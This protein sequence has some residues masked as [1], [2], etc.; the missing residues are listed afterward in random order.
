LALFQI[1]QRSHLTAMRSS[2]DFGISSHTCLMTKLSRDGFRNRCQIDPVRIMTDGLS[3][4]SYRVTRDGRAID[5]ALSAWAVPTGPARPGASRG[6]VMQM[7]VPSPGA[8][9]SVILPPSCCVT[10]VLTM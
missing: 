9:T 1:P 3:K 10:R 8:E 4:A 7:V 2:P 6:S 5:Y